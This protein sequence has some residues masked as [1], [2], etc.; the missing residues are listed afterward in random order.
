MKENTSKVSGV[1]AVNSKVTALAALTLSMVLFGT[2][3]IFRRYIPLSSGIIAM[4]RG[5]VGTVFI[6]LVIM[7]KGLKPSIK[8]IKENAI[9]LCLSGAAIGFNWILLFEAYR[10]TTVAVATLCYYMAPVFVIM[11]S[12]VLFREKLTVKKIGCVLAAIWGMVLVSGVLKSEGSAVAELKGVISGLGAAVLY[13]CVIL[14]NKKIKNISAYDKTMVQLGVAAVVLIP[15]ILMT[16]NLSAIT[17]S[18]VALIMLLV[19]GVL[20]TGI[21]YTLYFGAISSLNAQT[22]AIYSYIDPVVAIILSALVLHE[23]MGILEIIGAGMILCA[24]MIS[25]KS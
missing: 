23:E 14:I 22:T 19:V 8:A 18:P 7:A 3:G 10:Y 5:V 2:I 11:L 13:A 16:E 12:P 20:H 25:E 1:Q 4:T 9:L 6:A 21:A 15:Y 24:A 17:F